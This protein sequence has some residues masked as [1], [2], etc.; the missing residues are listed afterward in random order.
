MNNCKDCEV[1]E[2]CKEL[3]EKLA[4]EIKVDLGVKAQEVIILEES[5]FPF[6]VLDLIA[7]VAKSYS[8]LFVRILRA[9][10]RFILTFSASP[11][12]LTLK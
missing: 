3:R 12:G 10:L 9:G 1:R 2:D 5:V 4:H 7:R 8:I 11:L 6:E